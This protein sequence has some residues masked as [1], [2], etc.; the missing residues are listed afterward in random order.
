MSGVWLFVAQVA[1]SPGRLFCRL[2]VLPR[3]ACRPP[4]FL[5]PATPTALAWAA[6][7]A[8]AAAAA[9]AMAA[10][11]SPSSTPAAPN[12]Y[13]QLRPGSQRV[14]GV[15]Q[16]QHRKLGGTRATSWTR[17]ICRRFIIAR[18]SPLTT[19]PAMGCVYELGLDGLHAVGH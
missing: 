19:Q 5:L 14:H 3:G 11:G 8:A 2:Q 17:G 6:A 12:G 10:I 13:L 4:R 18:C 1:T 9:S 16:H 15:H 7:V